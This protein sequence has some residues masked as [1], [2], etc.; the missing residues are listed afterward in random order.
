M[1]REVWIGWKTIYSLFCCKNNLH[2]LFCCK[3][4][5]HTFFVTKIIYVPFFCRKNNL[6]TLSGKFLRVEVCRLESFDS[7]VSGPL[8]EIKMSSGGLIQ[9]ISKWGSMKQ[10][11]F[12]L[13]TC[14]CCHDLL[15]FEIIWKGPTPLILISIRNFFLGHS[16][17]LHKG[18]QNVL[19]TNR[20]VIC[21]FFIL[22]DQI[23]DQK[24]IPGK[25]SNLRAKRQINVRA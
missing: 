10:K 23:S 21:P 15:Q 12:P 14:Y 4:D 24:N 9:I 3:N 16:V 11:P 19:I 20:H 8:I 22:P 2:T 7:W 13:A 1:V 17:L 5:L 25:A 18:S 6:C